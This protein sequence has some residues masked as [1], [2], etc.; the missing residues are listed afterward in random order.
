MNLEYRM[1]DCIETEQ[2]ILKE[3]DYRNTTCLEISEANVQL[4]SHRDSTTCT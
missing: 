1:L 3:Q 2:V 4:G